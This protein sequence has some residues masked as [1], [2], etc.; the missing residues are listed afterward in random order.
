MSRRLLHTLNTNGARALR[1]DFSVR[2]EVGM[3]LIEVM[4]ALAIGVHITVKNESEKAQALRISVKLLPP[5]LL[6]KRSVTPDN[7]FRDVDALQPK[8][9]EARKKEPSS[10]GGFFDD[11]D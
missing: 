9:E 1:S 11:F 8:L 2:A 4:V 10:S 3:S 5:F 7:F 6:L